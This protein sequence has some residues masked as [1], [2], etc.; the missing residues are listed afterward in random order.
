MCFALCP[1]LIGCNCRT[2]CDYGYDVP[3]AQKW[4]FV[5]SKI[6]Q[7]QSCLL[8]VNPPVFGPCDSEDSEWDLG[9]ANETTSQIKVGTAGGSQKCLKFI[10]GFEATGLFLDSC[11]TEP[12][13]CAETRCAS[14]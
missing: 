10:G 13:I 2:T 11:N 4:S 14:S 5:G 1:Q 7:G 8:A 3:A 6:Q 12:Q 9:R